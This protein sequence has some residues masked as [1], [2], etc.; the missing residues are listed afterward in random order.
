MDCGRVPLEKLRGSRD[1][2]WP[3][4]LGNLDGGTTMIDG[5]GGW[6]YHLGSIM[7]GR[8]GCPSEVS[9][10]TLSQEGLR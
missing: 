3:Q 10:A 6:E 8:E 2:G 9:E 7:I 5:Q 4:G 1:L